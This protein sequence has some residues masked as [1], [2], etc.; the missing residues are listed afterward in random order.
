MPAGTATGSYR[1]GRFELEPTERRLLV[2]GAPV[3]LRRRTFDLLVA[4]VERRGNLVT[5]NE[6]LERVWRSVVVEENALQRQISVLRKVLGAEAIATVAGSGY[7]FTPEVTYVDATPTTSVPVPKHNLPLQLTSFIGRE[8]EIAELKQLLG[9]IR[10]LTLTGAGGSG[11]TRL[12]LEVVAELL[13]AYRDGIWLVELAPLE[14][15][16][17]VAQSVANVLGIKEQPGKTLT[18]TISEHLASRQA[19]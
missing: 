12:A 1:F 7:R 5:K 6:L 17:L 4:L 13:S 2:S 11:K 10:L 18:E 14:N 15:P 19:L 8:K 9:G 3:H 16:G